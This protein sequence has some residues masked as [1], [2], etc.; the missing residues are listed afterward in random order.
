MARNYKRDRNGKFARTGSSG[1]GKKT[2][3]Q[4]YQ[5]GHK[6]AGAIHRRRR[7]Q[8]NSGRKRDKLKVL[9]KSTS[10]AGGT[11][12]AASYVRHRRARKAGFAS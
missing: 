10:Y 1:K 4:R 7:D 6:G 12:H 8:W 5:K 9:A 3:K 11:A 2:L